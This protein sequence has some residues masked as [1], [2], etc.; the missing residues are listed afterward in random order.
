[1]RTAVA[2]LLVSLVS[3]RAQTPSV[4]D[5][6]SRLNADLMRLKSATAG[7]ADLQKTVARAFREDIG[8][9][10]S[11]RNFEMKDEAAVDPLLIAGFV[12][13]KSAERLIALLVGKNLSQA[14]LTPL[15]SAILAMVE[16]AVVCRNTHT[17]LKDSAQF[18]VAAEAAYKALPALGLHDP[19][20]RIAMD[21]LFAR[22]LAVSRRPPLQPVYK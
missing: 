20:V 2:C 17:S 4:D 3:A 13:G 18:Q 21:T 1:M 19:E 7:D 9:F 6:I 16:S 22:T 5:F 14:N 15:N 8:K 12:P 10:E 11:Q